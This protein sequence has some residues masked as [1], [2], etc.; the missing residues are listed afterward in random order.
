MV[1]TLAKDGAESYRYVVAENL[2][3]ASEAVADVI[4]VSLVTDMLVFVDPK[5]AVDRLH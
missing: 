1:K 4:A 3:A 5:P 2:Q